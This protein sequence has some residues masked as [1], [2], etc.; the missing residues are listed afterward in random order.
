[1][2]G[3]EVVCSPHELAV[4]NLANGTSCAMGAGAR[5]LNP[6]AARCEVCPYSSGSADLRGLNLLDASYG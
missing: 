1:M 6:A 2:W 4:F 5:L 3:T